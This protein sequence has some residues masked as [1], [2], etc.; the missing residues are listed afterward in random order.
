MTTLYITEYARQGLC[1]RDVE[2]GVPEELNLNAQT[3]ALGAASVQCGTVLN[4]NTRLIRIQTD[5]P[6]NFRLGPNPTALVTDAICL[7]AS[8][9]FLGVNMNDMALGTWKVAAISNPGAL[10]AG[11]FRGTASQTGAPQRYR[12]VAAAT[13]NA[14]NIKA[15]A[16]NVYG[17]NLVNVAAAARWVRLFNKATAPVPGTDTP[18]DTYQL[19]AGADLTVSWSLGLPFSLGIGIDITGA[20]PDN[21]ATATAVGDVIAHV[22][23]Q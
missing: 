16:G 20:A 2:Q 4:A 17:L 5:T 6:C 9:L 18:T 23:Y 15:S 22:E 1:P 10:D 14:A 21:D 11:G 19:A 3:I 8:P 13:T 7:P 12:V